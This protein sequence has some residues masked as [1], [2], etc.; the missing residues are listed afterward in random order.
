MNTSGRARNGPAVK[1][2]TRVAIP[3][4]MTTIRRPALRPVTPAAR[5]MVRLPARLRVSDEFP[6]V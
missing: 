4:R 1:A 2:G 3:A 6:F 5:R